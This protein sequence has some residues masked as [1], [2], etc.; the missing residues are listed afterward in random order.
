MKF[1]FLLIICLIPLLGNSQTLEEVRKN[2]HMAVLDPEKSEEFHDFLKNTTL[3]T[4]TLKAYKAASE[5]MFARAVWNPFT[6]FSQVLKYA[7]LMEKAIEEDAKNAEIRF[8]RFAIE[9]NLPRFLGMSKHLDEDLK[10][11]VASRTSIP[12]MNLDASFSRYI[13]YF[14]RGTGLT[15]EREIA[16]MEKDL[17]S[18]NSD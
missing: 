16:Q 7:D 8:L 6:K 12:S 13:V 4:P 1:L 3:S 17:V 9:Y 5:V 14:L 18:R 11:I 2:F 10:L 15:T